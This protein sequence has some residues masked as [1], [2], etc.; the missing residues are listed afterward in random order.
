MTKKGR[1]YIAYPTPR[2][3]FMATDLQITVILNTFWICYWQPFSY[4]LHFMFNHFVA[5]EIWQC[6]RR[7]VN[8]IDF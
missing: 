1:Q 2:G 6:R 3:K 8:K 5:A 7:S 4:W